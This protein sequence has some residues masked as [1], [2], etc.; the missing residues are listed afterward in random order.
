MFSTN[1]NIL[2]K[3]HGEDSS[4]IE[5]CLAH[6]EKNKVKSIYD[7][8]E[9]YKY[10]ENKRIVVQWYADWLDNLFLIK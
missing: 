4:I 7:R 6:K 9:K 3:E 1:A 10:L 2:K 8:E 5:C